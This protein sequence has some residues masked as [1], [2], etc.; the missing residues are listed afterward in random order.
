M[1]RA[2]LIFG[3]L[4]LSASFVL[5]QES[6]CADGGCL[7][8]EGDTVEIR[9]IEIS[10]TSISNSRANLITRGASSDLGLEE[11][12]PI[13][14]DY[15]LTIRQ[16]NSSSIIIETSM[17]FITTCWSDPDK[18]TGECTLYEEKT[19]NAV[20][21]NF[22]HVFNIV[23]ISEN[24]VEINVSGYLSGSLAQ[25]SQ[26]TIP[27][28]MKILTVN[29]IGYNSSEN[30]PS[31]VKFGVAP[32]SSIDF[33]LC[34]DTDGGKE[35]YIFGTLFGGVDGHV[36]PDFCSLNPPVHSGV[37]FSDRGTEIEQCSGSNCY[38]IES[39]CP[40]R[41]REETQGKMIHEPYL[42]PSGCSNG[43]CIG[44]PNQSVEIPTGRITLPGQNDSIPT[45]EITLPGEGNV[46]S[47]NNSE[48]PETQTCSGCSLNDKCYTFGYRKAGNYCNEEGINFTKYK[49][50]GETCE[51]NFECKS[52]YCIDN[53]CISGGLFRR[54]SNWFRRIF[55]KD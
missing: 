38:L 8:Y 14:D 10:L 25:G 11:S 28:N 13:S 5:S 50:S 39:F 55:G 45:G 30:I 4:I 42:C 23:S 53:E 16:I 51:N 22:M 2:I 17:R 24:S 47:P 35:Y 29:E 21:G 44:D 19:T 54:V 12:V 1:K 46:F 27:Y 32:N 37:I 15:K 48:N 7:I 18:G 40:G 9:G 49:A 34:T 41:T 43:A 3:L 36:H 52:N 26:Y 20:I 31:F 33:D 6:Y